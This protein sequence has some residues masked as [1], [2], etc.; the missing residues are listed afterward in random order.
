MQVQCL[1]VEKA[2]C[3]KCPT[4]SKGR[5]DQAPKGR[6]DIKCTRADDAL[7]SANEMAGS[8]E[9]TKNGIRQSGMMRR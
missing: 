9:Q 3:R 8:T 7:V 6:K 4:L 5:N 1:A 2:P